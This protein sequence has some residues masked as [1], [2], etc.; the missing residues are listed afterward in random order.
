MR[1]SKRCG[2]A[3]LLITSSASASRVGPPWGLARRGIEIY[4]RLD[5]AQSPSVIA[6]FALA[7][8]RPAA[9]VCPWR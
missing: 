8:A 7:R 3:R 2:V 1:R 4:D 9:P 5:L 6:A